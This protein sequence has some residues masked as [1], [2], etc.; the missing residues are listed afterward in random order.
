MQTP[1]KPIIAVPDLNVFVSGIAFSTGHPRS[2][3]RLWKQ[4]RFVLATSE[5]MLRR[6]QRVLL[7]PKIQRLTHWTTADV[8]R[9]IQTVRQKAKVVKGTGNVTISPD[10]K[11]NT[12]I[13]CALEAQAHYLISGDTRHVL[14]VERYQG[15]EIVSPKEFVERVMQL[16]KAA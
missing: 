10:P 2:V 3:L 8:E 15:I 4:G 11:D 1:H 7:Y 16:E 6:M 14:P 13:A 9:Y 12:V 5:V